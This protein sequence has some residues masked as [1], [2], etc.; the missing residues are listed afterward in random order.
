MFDLSER[1]RRLRWRRLWWWSEQSITSSGPSFGWKKER[2][3]IVSSWITVSLRTSAAV[4]AGSHCIEYGLE[5]ITFVE[6]GVNA[7]KLLRDFI[8]SAD[9]TMLEE[10]VVEVL[11]AV[12]PTGGERRVVAILR[13]IRRDVVLVL[14][15]CRISFHHDGG[16]VFRKTEVSLYPPNFRSV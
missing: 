3:E 5:Q 15:K 14:G 1:R 10:R 11:G 13:P 16:G 4:L 7:V 8:H 2:R 12:L 9:R 6:P